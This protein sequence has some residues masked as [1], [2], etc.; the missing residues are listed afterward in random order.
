MKEKRQG[1]REDRKG[2]ERGAD[3]RHTAARR[4]RCLYTDFPPHCSHQCLKPHIHGISLSLLQSHSS[5]T[6]LFF[7]LK[8]KRAVLTSF[9]SLFL[10]SDELLNMIAYWTEKCTVLNEI[11]I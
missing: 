6:L 7:S 1:R 3:V 9:R 4:D 10:G 8:N 2:R 11:L 5:I